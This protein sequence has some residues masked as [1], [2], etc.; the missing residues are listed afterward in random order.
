MIE[1]RFRSLLS[2][3]SKQN[4]AE[5]GR[6]ATEI[7]QLIDSGNYPPFSLNRTGFDWLMWVVEQHAES[8]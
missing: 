2:A 5:A 7:R 3:L 4:F 1:E 8:P 6:L